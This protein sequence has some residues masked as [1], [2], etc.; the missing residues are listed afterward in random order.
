V[1]KNRSTV[2]NLLRLLGL[3]PS[4]RRL[5]QDGD[6]SM[7]HARALLSVEDTVRASELARKAVAEGWS[8]R[9]VERR[10]ARAREG[11]E[12]GTRS[13]PSTGGRGDSRDPVVRALE[14]ALR[15]TLATRVRIKGISRSKGMI[16]VPF[17]GTEDFERLF[18]LIAG[19]E[20]SDV[21]S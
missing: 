13:A 10:A 4:I 15:E 17:H 1:G 5:L 12:G 8:V 6:L 3:P 7:G 14:E 9:E 11:S 2:A 16:E 20:A 18:A 21:V 19:R